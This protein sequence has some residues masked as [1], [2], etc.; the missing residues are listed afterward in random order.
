MSTVYKVSYI[1]AQP[2]SLALTFIQLVNI[3]PD[4]HEGALVIP[5][6]VSDDPRTGRIALF[7]IFNIYLFLRSR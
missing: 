7:F 2:F 3:I 1:S 6:R 4:D 5:K